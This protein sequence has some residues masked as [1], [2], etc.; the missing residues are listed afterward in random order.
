MLAPL[1]CGSLRLFEYRF[2]HD[3]FESLETRGTALHLHAE[4]CAFPRRQKKFGQFCG[5]ESG[6]DFAGGLSR[7]DARPKHSSPLTKN[8]IEALA[9][10]LAVRRGLKAEV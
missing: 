5:V 8:C 9:Q 7:G 1:N 4:N 2:E 10:E 3:G 6:I